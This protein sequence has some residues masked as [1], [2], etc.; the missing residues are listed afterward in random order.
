MGKRYRIKEKHPKPKTSKKTGEVK[1]K[2][3]TMTITRRAGSG[4]VMYAARFFG[5]FFIAGVSHKA[6]PL[7]CAFTVFPS[8][9]VPF[10]AVPQ[11]QGFA[12]LGLN[13]EEA[14]DGLASSAVA[15]APDTPTCFLVRGASY[16]VGG[17]LA[18]H[19][20][21]VYS[22]AAQALAV[23]L[24]AAGGASGSG[25]GSSSSHGLVFGSRTC[26]VD[27]DGSVAGQYTIYSEHGLPLRAGVNASFP[28]AGVSTC[29]RNANSTA[30]AR[31]LPPTNRR[32]DTVVRCYSGE[33][34]VPPPPP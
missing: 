3:A 34:G 27:V 15:R 12:S 9:T 22:V 23:G 18:N 8:K 14:E 16:R 30:A 2:A 24:T 20:T 7:C 19:S 31:N 21:G 4:K 13:W 11:Q 6:L 29:C 32:S 33:T 25:S 10:C 26:C 5:V 1:Q 17:V 28:F